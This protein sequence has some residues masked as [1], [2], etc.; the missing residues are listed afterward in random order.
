MLLL[1]WLSVWPRTF[2]GLV[3]VCNIQYSR[4]IHTSFIHKHLLR[5]ISISFIIYLLQNPASPPTITA[6]YGPHTQTMRARGI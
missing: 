3:A 1:Q 2:K 6:T 5:P 4:Y